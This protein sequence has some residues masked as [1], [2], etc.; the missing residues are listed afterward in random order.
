MSNTSQP[1]D[2]AEILE[3]SEI[4]LA[5]EIAIKKAEAFSAAVQAFTLKRLN[6]MVVTGEMNSGIRQIWQKS[7]EQMGKPEVLQK[8]ID[9][10]WANR[11]AKMGGSSVVVGELM[12]GK[13]K[14]N[15][16]DEEPIQ[17]KKKEDIEI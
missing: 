17:E 9:T 2:E 8:R 4:Q 3:D 13:G 10:F 5:G 12:G 6:E 14:E 15:E 16:E 11:Q 1:S 7:M